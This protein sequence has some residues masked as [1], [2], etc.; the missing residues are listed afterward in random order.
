MLAPSMGVHQSIK[1][2]AGVSFRR[3]DSGSTK[4]YRVATGR[5]SDDFDRF[6]LMSRDQRMTPNAE[7][8]ESFREALA[9]SGILDGC[10]TDRILQMS[11]VTRA[12]KHTKIIHAGHVPHHCYFIVRGL[13]RYFYQAS[14]GKEWNKAFFRENEWAGS[15]NSYLTGEACAFSIDVLENSILISIPLALFK[16]LDDVHPELRTLVQHKIQEIM[17]R[18]EQREGMLLTLNSESR[19]AWICHHQRWLLERVAQYHLASYLGIE[20]QSLSRLKRSVSL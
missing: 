2:N 12:S 5:G 19:Y 13:A 11:K 15:L 6:G 4:A 7:Y 14:N 20:P 3:E 16:P 1:R 17:L 9:T 8:L 18:N 10:L